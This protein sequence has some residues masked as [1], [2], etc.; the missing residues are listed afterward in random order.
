MIDASR[1]S[2]DN[3]VASFQPSLMIDGWV[4]SDLTTLL[5]AG[6][7]GGGILLLKAVR[8]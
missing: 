4:M 8:T 6:L 1:A 3:S 5:I 2:I 7:V